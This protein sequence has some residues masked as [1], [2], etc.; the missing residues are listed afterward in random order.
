MMSGPKAAEHLAYWKQHLA[1]AP[2]VL[3]IPTDR[4]RRMASRFTGRTWSRRITGSLLENIA[5]LVRSRRLTPATLFLSLYQ[6][7]LSRY[8]GEEDI[9][10]GMSAAT[11]PRPEFAE[12]IGYFINMVPLRMRV[13]RA[14]RWCDH[15]EELQACMADGLDHGVYPFPALVRDLKVARSPGVPPVFQVAFTFVKSLDAHADG[16]S[17]EPVPGLH[18]EGEFELVLEVFEENDGF[19][20]NLKYNPELFDEATI[21]RMMDHYV[22]LATAVVEKPTAALGEVALLDQAERDTVVRRWN[23][24]Q[25]D[26]PKDLCVHD[27]LH[28][29]FGE[30]PTPSR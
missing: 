16:L 9:V 7:L 10:V 26:Y 24:T 22:A 15:V 23:A 28:N 29:R 8:S 14:R 30:R 5:S 3:A 12:L 4:P 17:I 20:L 2:A 21:V 18:Q 6:L 25:V 27:C 11:R 13:E 19:L 1:G